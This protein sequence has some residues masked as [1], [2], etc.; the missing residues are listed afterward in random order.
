M[1]I[2]LLTFYFA[3][4]LS[5]G[6]FRNTS[7]VKAFSKIFN[8]DDVLHVV[9][10]KPNRYSSFRVDAP[11]FEQHSENI[12][13]HRVEVPEHKSGF[14]DQI[15]T[16]TK[17]YIDVKQIVK[18][19]SFD[20]VVASSSRL[21]TA[22][23]GSQVAAE[24]NAKLYLDIRDL[25]RETILDVIKNPLLK[26]PLNALLRITERRT[27]HRADHINVVSEGFNEYFSNYHITPSFHPNG[28]DDVFIIDDQKENNKSNSD[29]KYITYAGN[30]GDG[31]GLHNI[32]PQTAKLIAQ[33]PF[34]FRIIGDGGKMKELQDLLT[35]ESID[36]VEIIAPVDRENLIKYYKES[37]ILFLHLNN[38][39]AFEKV[40]PSKIFEYAAIG[41][42]IIA[43]V[44]GYA[45]QFLNE[46]VPDAFVFDPCDVQALSQFLIR[47]EM[48]GNIEREEFIQIFSRDAIMSKMAHEIMEL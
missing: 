7:L 44:S 18:K 47:N 20:V 38:Y 43:G 36:N 32:V 30:V 29:I 1:K 22:Y 42:P 17:Y 48:T 9:T 45:K 37:D 21:F 26:V 46:N 35:S 33:T 8:D 25:F 12:F 15:K 19:E 16:F 28:I 11:T 31:Q 39:K 3:P 40:L 24:K 23:L 27:F 6:S 14:T 5:A 13:I 2:L 10:T 4:D 41:K 34:K